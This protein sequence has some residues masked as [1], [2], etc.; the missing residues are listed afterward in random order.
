MSTAGFPAG[1]MSAW[2]KANSASRVP[3][4]G[5]TWVSGSMPFSGSRKRRISQ[6]AMD[7]RSSGMPL[8]SG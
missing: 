8:V 5:S 4:T 7:S 1:S 3:F 2:A 6:P